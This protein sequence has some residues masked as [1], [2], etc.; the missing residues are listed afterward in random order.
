[1]GNHQDM[2]FYGLTVDI[3]MIQATLDWQLKTEVS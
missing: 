1:M 2:G 3:K